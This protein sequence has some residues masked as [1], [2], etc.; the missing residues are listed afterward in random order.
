MLK[1]KS[2]IVLLS[3]IA[4]SFLNPCFGKDSTQRQPR[5]PLVFLADS[6]TY[7]PDSAE[8]EPNIMFIPIIFEKQKIIDLS[9]PAPAPIDS[10]KIYYNNIRG[11]L[12][13]SIDN[14]NFEYYF[15]NRVI[16]QHPELV[17]YNLAMLP[18]PPKQYII[19][20]EPNQLTLTLEESD[21]KKQ[22]LDLNINK[23]FKVKGWL[24]S[25]NASLQFSQAYVSENWYQGGTSNLNLL[26]GLNYNVKLNPN[27]YP[28]LMF[29]N[30][31]QYKLNL[32]SA[33]Q[34]SLHNY[35]ISEDLLQ[36]NTIFGL[37]ATHNWFYT[38][39]A[40]FKTQIFNNYQTNS[41]TLKASFLTPGELNLGLGMT[42]NRTNTQKTARIDVSIAP[43]SYN[44]KI[45]RDIDNFD[46]TTIGIS[47]GKH[48]ISQVGSN[49]ES[50]F[51]W[52]LMA[53]ITLNSRIY[54]FT[55]YSYIQGDWENT[56]NFSI[57]KYLS[58][59]IYMHLRY[60]SSLPSDISWKKWQFKEILSFGF[61][62]KI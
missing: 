33:P 25:F 2:I 10:S 23:N 38:A 39:T 36:L 60:D 26:A 46:A 45:C 57:N 17:K 51:S 13:N 32:S 1:L 14:T 62:Y 6:T 47:E 27:V 49:I 35:S 48:A 24:K 34:D 44:L 15:I 19:K 8:I 61:N 7:I 40:M 54:V 53:N 22:P 30:N 56:F 18:E 3:F 58:T 43:I 31:I 20:S 5:I 55:D 21:L 52:N 12:D 29:E 42:Y 11:W 4:A 28:N 37:K 9:I 50:K 59:Q 41:H 16:Y